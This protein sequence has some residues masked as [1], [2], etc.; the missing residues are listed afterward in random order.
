VSN[1][2]FSPGDQSRLDGWDGGNEESGD[3]S[4]NPDGDRATDGASVESG[5][6]GQ[7]SLDEFEPDR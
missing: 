3:G 2:S 7:V 1:L 6:D 5:D 4:P